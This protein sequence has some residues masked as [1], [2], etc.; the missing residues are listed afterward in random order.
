MRQRGPTVPLAGTPARPGTACAA[1][2]HPEPLEP[3]AAPPPAR[4]TWR[5]APGTQPRAPPRPWHRL[6]PP[7][8]A[9]RSRTASLVC[10]PPSAAAVFEDSKGHG[11]LVLACTHFLAARSLTG[12]SRG[13]VCP[14]GIPRGPCCHHTATDVRRG[15]SLTRD[16]KPPDSTSPF[17]LP[18]WGQR[19]GDPQLRFHCFHV[20]SLNP[21][22]LLFPRAS[23][24]TL[25]GHGGRG[26]SH[27]G[28]ALPPPHPTTL[29]GNNSI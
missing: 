11:C 7:S 27:L 12:S 1:P 26:C 4:H 17:L 22:K 3:R 20:L 23:V 29:P 2:S 21:G 28:W 16:W 13:A 10:L 9:V 25:S 18:A 8:G 14:S 5:R 15:L 19:E 24:F 6:D